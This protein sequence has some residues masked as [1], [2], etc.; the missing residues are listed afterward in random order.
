MFHKESVRIFIL[1]IHI[2]ITLSFLVFE[3]VCVVK[4]LSTTT[5]FLYE[6][7]GMK[8]NEESVHLRGSVSNGIKNGNLK[9]SET[10]HVKSR[11]F[12]PLQC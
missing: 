12:G 8:E 5:E 9:K 2:N 6:Y 11:F 3:I 4:N 10:K 1:C 7:S